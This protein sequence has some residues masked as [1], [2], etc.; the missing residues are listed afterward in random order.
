MVNSHDDFE[1]FPEEKSKSQIKREMEALQ[2][3]GLRLTELN[4][5]QLDQVPMGESLGG[6]IREYQRLKKGEAK[7]RQMQYVGRVMRSIDED[8]IEAITHAIN[9]FDASQVEHTQRFHQSG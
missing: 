7:R 9:R 2:A 8:D 1:D 6:A 5:D 3:L 4:S